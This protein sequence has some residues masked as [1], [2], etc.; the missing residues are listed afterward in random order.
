MAE[1]LTD[2]QYQAIVDKHPGVR[3]RRVMTAA[4]ELVIRAPTTVE[5]STFQN[6]FFGSSMHAG[7]CWRNL[8]VMLTVHPEQA[9]MQAA[10]NDWPGLPINPKVIRELKLIRGEA[11]E[12]EG[13]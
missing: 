11:D 10:L 5:E 7:L 3:L 8:L 13:K 2:E 12:E 4:G 6:M 1:R 9:R